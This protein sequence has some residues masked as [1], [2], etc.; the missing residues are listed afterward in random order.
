M[1]DYTVISAVSETLK[2]VLTTALG[3]VDPA[4]KAVYFDFNA[5]PANATLSIFLFEVGE[6][7][8]ARNH[9]RVRETTPP[10]MKIRKPPIALLLRYLLTPWGGDEVTKQKI[11]GKTMQV[12]YDRAILNGLDLNGVLADTDDQLK[13]TL[14]PLSLEER[15]RVWHAINK[16]YHLSVSYEVRVVNL[17]SESARDVTPVTRRT[18]DFGGL[19]S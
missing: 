11:L 15:T 1:A 19:T 5:P 9:P 17:D 7:P 2:G 14:A 6:D 13:V 3:T 12:L 4:F 8:S 16:P 10:N 18:E